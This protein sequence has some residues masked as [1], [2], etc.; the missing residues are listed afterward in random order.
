MNKIFVI[1]LMLLSTSMIAQN[2]E[3]TGTITDKDGNPLPGATIQIKDVATA[4]IADFDGNFTL[5]AT[6]GQVLLASY[7]GY[8]Q[9]LIV[10]D[11]KNNFII[12]LIED[13]QNLD[14]VV[15]IGY[16]SVKKSDLTGAVASVKAKEIS[17]SG[18]ISVDQAL[19]GRVSGVVV[20]QSSGMLGAGATIK[21]RGLSSMQ[22]SDP[23]YII[24]GVPMDNASS[25]SIND[26]DEQSSQISPLSLINPADIL[27]LEVLKDASATAI[28]GSRGSN[29]VILITTKSG[30]IGKGTV[31]VTTE[32]G[33]SVIQKYIDVM[34]ANQFVLTRME[35]QRNGTGVY[36]ETSTKRDS[37]M[38][39]LYET[40]NWQKELISPAHSKNVNVSF[41]GGDK[42]M[43]YLIST[44]G[45][46]ANGLVQKTN[47]NRFTSRINLSANISEKLKVSTSINYSSVSTEKQST[48][49]NFNE[50]NG[51]NSVIMRALTFAPSTTLDDISDNENSGINTPSPLTFID[52]NSWNTEI[53]QFL[54][55][56][57]LNYKI[58]KNLNWDTR[59]SQQKRFSEQGF[60]QN[61]L[62]K[63]YSTFKNGWA[64][65]KN[66]TYTSFSVTNALNYNLRLN[67][68]FQIN[69]VLGQSYETREQKSFG[70]SNYGFENDFLTYFDPGSAE[71]S[72]KDTATYI[73][74]VMLSFFGR[75][76]LTFDNKF[77][78]TFTGRFDGSSK[79]AAN[80]KWGFFPSG[81]FAY[82]I[83]QEQFI[84]DINAISNLKLR[85]SYG[86]TGNQGL[87]AYSSLDR[88]ASSQH[89][90]GTG[91]GESLATVF[92][93]S[94]LPNAD[95]RWE[96]TAQF[97]SGLDVG[98][99]KNKI[100]ITADYFRKKT[101]DFLVPKNPVAS[102]SGFT[103]NV[104]NFGSLETNGFDLG[105]NY[106]VITKNEF[107][108]T[109]NGT[110]SVGK[111]KIT[112]MT[113]D[114]VSSGYL[115]ANITGGTQRLIVGEA[116][117]TFYGLKRAGIA[118]FDDFVEFDGLSHDE[119]VSLYNQNRIATYTYKEDYSG[120]ITM[121]GSERP[122]EQLYENYDNEDNVIDENDKQILG[123][124]QPDITFGI[125]NTF[126]I[127]AFD[128]SVFIDSQLGQEV[129]NLANTRLFSF[130][131][132][133][134]LAEVANSAWTPENQSTT[135]PRLDTQ[136]NET[137]YSD[138]YVEDASFIRLKSVNF[139]YNLPKRGLD[140]LN[141]SSLRFYIM[142]T[143]LIMSTKYS[144]FNPDVSL[145]GS[146][147]LL[148]GHDNAG[149]PASTTY[150]IGVNIKI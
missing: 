82:K 67:R 84:Q 81:A 60:Y 25:P 113:S 28:Y 48:N 99:F 109:L 83:H 126:K 74:T 146:N 142:G 104:I 110:M 116:L 130:N 29:G 85:I 55:S 97:N 40:Q 102:Q 2:K 4:T 54:G 133:Q 136:N 89:T 14:E 101:T 105:I 108:W 64:K 76:N 49:T 69:G 125:N 15:L 91:S 7:T 92:F 114:Y 3:I 132:N 145:S 107:S 86:I 1:L 6:V 22:N 137:T 8:K 27:S 103:S 45:L 37:A 139:G 134:Q 119:R 75:L 118:Q 131:G 62:Q 10:V 24:D 143:N 21:I 13:I 93:R 72:E 127:G 63:Y 42:N 44:N 123:N 18:A 23:L 9:Q 96:N 19:A 39:G 121:T 61:S 106:H 26:G 32:Y 51:T 135:H 52:A 95:L 34:D 17:E 70:S 129:T 35:A 94:Q 148:L 87:A 31:Q 50:N 124:A 100:N 5:N 56:V 138:R 111:T 68:K 71:F 117:G 57:S 20:N 128:L 98:L 47:F 150:R 115:N 112:E 53:T 46:N 58:N 12:Q 73:E 88:M 41:S 38:S 59:V 77:L 122:G 149:Y 80:N 66:S 144:G 33:V 43:K 30:E 140:Y 90:F 78:F 16:G 147:S 65:I 79:F 36:T 141:I 120:G 11:K